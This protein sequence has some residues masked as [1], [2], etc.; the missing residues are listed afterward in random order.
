MA[1]N[2]P[3]W[4]TPQTIHDPSHADLLEEV[5]RS[6]A[7]ELEKAQGL[8]MPDWASIAV[9]IRPSAIPRETADPHR[10]IEVI[11][12]EFNCHYNIS[13][14]AA[15]NPHVSPVE[16]LTHEIKTDQVIR[17]DGGWIQYKGSDRVTMIERFTFAEQTLTATVKGTT[18][19]AAYVCGRLASLLWD[20][21]GVPRKWDEL[22]PL[23][24]SQAYHT[25]TL[26]DLGVPMLSLL[27]PTVREFI[28]SLCSTDGDAQNMGAFGSRRERF[29]FSPMV[30]PHCREI[31]FRFSLIDEVSGIQE[32][33][34]FDLLLHTRSDANRSRVKV[35]SE[36]EFS[37]HTNVVLQLIKK[38]RAA[39]VAA[40]QDT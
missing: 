6:V 40:K 24:E 14:V 15:I 7:A 33:C 35:L 20:A 19:E 21:A 30:I 22:A 28:H 23:A 17:F 31:E 13:K 12:R 26:V 1:I 2:S 37:K 9:N 11:E 29:K 3:N 25:S 4:G 18:E 16:A 32:E 5:E 27:S 36:L 8:I 10:I 38:L 34:T 39:D